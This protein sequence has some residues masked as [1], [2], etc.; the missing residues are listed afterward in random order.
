M[1]DEHAK[2]AHASTKLMRVIEHWMTHKDLQ[3]ALLRNAGINDLAFSTV[4][5]VLA[6]CPSL[7]TL[8]LAQNSLTMDSC[9]EICN[10]ITSAPQLS[11]VS[12]AENMF[13]LRSL[14]Y[15]MTAVMERQ[16]TKKLTPLD[17]L[18][19]HGNEGLIAA[20]AA[21]P[22]EGLFKQ[23]TAALGPTRLPP[24]GPE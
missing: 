11:F 3:Q 14:G 17:L 22:P 9:S 6:D 19:L 7:Q 24:R 16:N 10:L 21:P 15:F 18:D 12:L 8:D 20:A 23:V 4:V 13:S 1:E 2:G 5:Q